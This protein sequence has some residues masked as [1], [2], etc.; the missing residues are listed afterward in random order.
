[1]TTTAWATVEGLYQEGD[2]RH[3]P[4]RAELSRKGLAIVGSDGETVV[5]WR[6][7]DLVRTLGTDGFRIGARRQAGMFVFDPDTGSDLIRALASIPDVDAPMMPR[8]LASTM[9]VIVVLT[10]SALFVLGWGF[11]WVVEWLMAPGG[12]SGIPG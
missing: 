10:L 3:R 4:A 12:G 7:M 2:G 5:L 1:M 8:A 6:S 9:V 11:F